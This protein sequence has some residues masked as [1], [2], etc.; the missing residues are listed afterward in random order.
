MFAHLLSQHPL[1]FCASESG[2]K[3][4]ASVTGAAFDFGANI[5][6]LFRGES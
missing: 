2:R 1:E 4:L 6:K 3:L 5:G